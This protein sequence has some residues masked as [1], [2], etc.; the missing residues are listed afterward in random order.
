MLSK[1]KKIPNLSFEQMFENSDA[2]HLLLDPDTGEI[3]TA[4]PA[5]TRFYGWTK[6][7]LIGKK[8]A[9]INTL[10]P[11]EIQRSLEKAKNKK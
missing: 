4:N 3:I 6:E 9:E 8:I 7:E 2:I 5:A 10:S 1:L 11:T